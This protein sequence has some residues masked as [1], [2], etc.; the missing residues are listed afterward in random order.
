M[1]KTWPR[2]CR[3]SAICNLKPNE[4][5]DINLWHPKLHTH[6]Q[7]MVSK[8][9]PRVAV[10]VDDT[11]LFDGKVSDL[12][13]SVIE[14]LNDHY[15]VVLFTGRTDIPDE[16]WELTE[17]GESRKPAETRFTGGREW[18]I[19]KY[20]AWDFWCWIDDD[21]HVLKIVDSPVRLLVSDEEDWKGIRQA[22]LPGELPIEDHE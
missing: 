19:H 9:R 21:S 18:K 17:I 11:I 10:D 22:L 4:Y 14:E 13:K 8:F 16:V 3:I 7:S 1:K 5:K 6:R 2:D 15:M 12:A 20:E